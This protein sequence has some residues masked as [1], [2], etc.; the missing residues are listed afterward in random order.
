[1]PEVARVDD[2]SDKTNKIM[3]IMLKTGIPIMDRSQLFEQCARL[4]ENPINLRIN[5]IRRIDEDQVKFGS[6]NMPELIMR[7]VKWRISL[8]K[9]A[10]RYILRQLRAVI[11][12][13]QL[14]VLA[15]D[16]LGKIF[17]ELRN[18]A[19]NL[20]QR[21]ATALDISLEQAEIIARMQVRSLS[22]LTRDTLLADIKKHKRQVKQVKYHISHPAQKIAQDLSGLIK[23]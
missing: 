4:L 20:E 14:M 13:L 23:F 6:C 11:T 15:C 9:S 5:Y 10:Q 2:I 3:R 17:A 12:R 22:A 18:R 19:A 7:W 16:N 21:L 8:E 1:V